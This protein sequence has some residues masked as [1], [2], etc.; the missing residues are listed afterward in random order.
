M[1]S[2]HTFQIP[3]M[4]TGHSVD[5]PIRVA[6]LG[7]SSVISLVDDLL[8]E[9][10]RKFYSEKFT[11]PYE[12]IPRSAEDGRA[13][14]I[15][16]YL[17]T[18]AEVVDIKMGKLKQ[19]TFA[20]S[21]EK[22]SYFELLPGAS[23]LRVAYEKFVGLNEDDEKVRL[24]Q[25]LTEK[26]LPGSID[27]NI[28]S[29]LDRERFDKNGESLGS[30]FT[31]AKAA[32]RGFANSV[33][34]ASL[35]LSAGINQG[36]YTYMTKFSDFYHDVSGSI[37][38]KVVLKVSDFR[39]AMIQ[40]KFLAKKG[41]EVYEFRI[42]SGLNCGGHAFPSDGMLLPVLLQEYKEKRDQ[43]TGQFLPMVK[44]FYDKMGLEY[45]DSETQEPV[46]ITVQGGIG[47][48]GEDQRMCDYYGMDMTGWGTPFMLV[49]EATPVDDTTRE[50]LR[51][52]TTEDV[53]LSFSSPFGV[54]FNN[55]H[56]SGSDLWQQARVKAG[57][58]GSPCPK[59]FILTNTEFT[60]MPICTAS[61]EYQTKK[62]AQ[63]EEME[64]SEEKKAKLRNF[65]VVK[66]CICDHLGN[67]CLIDYGLIDEARAP[68]SVCP[69]PNVA[70]FNRIYSL[71]E[72]VDHI[73]GRGEC[74][75]PAKRP[76]MFATEIDMYVGYFAERVDDCDSPKAAKALVKYRNNLDAG[77]DYCLKVAREEKPYKDENLKSIFDC[78]EKQRPILA[79]LAEKLA[80][81]A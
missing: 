67:G 66:H 42:E 78:V 69:G 4:G 11:L 14:R 43:L 56:G 22:R 28:M 52:S 65:V 35:V 45:K 18:V 63:I 9:K 5:T 23:P 36:L 24:E 32:L 72:M 15:T 29:K 58:P 70:W 30:E 39:S 19:Q 31:D 17:D 13:R 77:M 71:K 46:M 1:N 73:Y 53:Y 81:F 8:L 57:T 75:T 21:S 61:T 47:T 3:V 6:H 34:E 64:I 74:L 68:Q 40:G 7:I 50:L 20:E 37:R 60:E 26:M 62:L 54:P 2:A 25:E 76:H 33:L 12:P 38:K 55:I 51:K 27:V 49:P 59:K 16:A 41:L 10:V 48:Y 79:K 80:Q 44:K